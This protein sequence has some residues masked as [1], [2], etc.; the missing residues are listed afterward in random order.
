MERRTTGKD[1]ATLFAALIGVGGVA[2]GALIAGLIS[3]FTIHAQLQHDSDIR[4]RDERR[5]TCIDALKSF[6]QQE[7]LMNRIY[8]DLVESGSTTNAVRDV[9]RLRDSSDVEDQSLILSLTASNAVFDKNT[10]YIK[11]SNAAIEM[12]TKLGA[13]PIAARAGS[14]ESQ[15]ASLSLRQLDSARLALVG[16][17]RS[18][19]SAGTR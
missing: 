9:E 8:N 17:C 11:A 19:L 2:V 6:R 5:S 4:L 7:L 14:V 3:W 13:L 15:R 16:A 10:E 12:L 1:R 18:D